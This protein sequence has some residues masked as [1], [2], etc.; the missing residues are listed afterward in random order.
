MMNSD[1]LMEICWAYKKGWIN[2]DNASAQIVVRIGLSED[3]AD[4]FLKGL[5]RDNVVRLECDVD[6]NN[7]E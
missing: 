3:V 4:S 5:P 7:E 2:L 6:E 1:A